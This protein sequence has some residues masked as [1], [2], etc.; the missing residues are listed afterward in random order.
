MLSKKVAAWLLFLACCQLH[1]HSE[2]NQD[3]SEITFVSSLP[4]CKVQHSSWIGD[5]RCDNDEYNTAQCNY[6]MGDCCPSTCNPLNPTSNACGVAGYRCKNPSAI[7]NKVPANS[8]GGKSG[9][10]S[11]GGGGGGNINDDCSSTGVGCGKS[12]DDFDNGNN[13]GGGGGGSGGGG[14]NGGGG[15]SGG[16]GDNGGGGGG[17]N[18]GGGGDNGGGGGGDNGGGSGGGG[19]G[20][21]GGDNSGGG[22]NGGGGGDNG[23]GGGDNGGGGG[24]NGGGGGNSGNNGGNGGGGGGGGGGDNGGGGGSSNNGG[25]GGGSGGGGGTTGMATRMVSFTR[26]FYVMNTTM[27][28][29]D[30]TDRKVTEVHNILKSSICGSILSGNKTSVTSISLIPQT[31][32][33]SL[34]SSESVHSSRNLMGARQSVMIIAV[35]TMQSVSSNKILE[36]GAFNRSLTSGLMQRTLRRFSSQSTTDTLN[37]VKV[38]R[39]RDPSICMKEV[40]MKPDSK[41]LVTFD[42]CSM[43]VSNWDHLYQRQGTKR[44]FT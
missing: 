36:D 2:L 38:C 26:R 17:N 27:E 8:A 28:C 25:G 24:D 23:G 32:S 33:S 22:G 11:N 15:G 42:Q 18:G 35:A 13:G 7:E 31:E 6:D 41:S 3:N 4:N 10:N 5:G 30:E 14:G 34:I 44:Y 40:W 1:A 16:G 20:G 37:W 19:N 21:G 12:D 39:S 9:S 43:T 29:F